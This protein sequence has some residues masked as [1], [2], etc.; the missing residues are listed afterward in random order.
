VA[1]GAVP[2]VPP[3][4]TFTPVPDDG[5][6]VPD[7]DTTQDFSGIAEVRQLAE[8]L[9]RE[10]AGRTAG[11]ALSAEL[12]RR[13]QAAQHAAEQE[14]P[15]RE[16]AAARRRRVTAAGRTVAPLTPDE[17][18][19]ALAAA[20][21]ER[22]DALRAD[23]ARHLSAGQ[24]RALR[25]GTLANAW[26]RNRVQQLLFDTENQPRPA[27]QQRLWSNV[28]ITPEAPGAPSVE[29]DPSAGGVD[30]GTVPGGQSAGSKKRPVLVDPRVAGFL[31]ALHDRFPTV[32]FETY[33]H[34]GSTGFAGRGLSL[35]VYLTG[36]NSDTRH[37]YGTQNDQG[38]WD[39][40]E[41][42]EL[43]LAVDETA[44]ETNFRFFAI[45][46]D[47]AVA[48]QANSRLRQGN[49]GFAGNVDRGGGLNYHGGGI[50][51]HVHLDLLPPDLATTERP[52]RR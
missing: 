48:R 26:M 2:D 28:W 33:G 39:R 42:Q 12:A 15:E 32:R 51:L 6:H 16:S 14:H 9:A 8:N 41:V 50:K 45:Y 47:F 1:A 49:V 21:R 19:A 4:V 23:W 24:A 27:G 17:Q 7:L 30:L 36:T 52:A 29:S 40:D 37:R 22:L 10:Y 3:P 31:T 11:A 35:D 34:H 18:G 43:L 38:F 25:A 13:R 20:E 5:R 46:N 44:V